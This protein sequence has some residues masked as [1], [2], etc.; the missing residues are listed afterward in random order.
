MNTFIESIHGRNPDEDRISIVT[1]T[2]RRRERED[3]SLDKSRWMYQ[4]CDKRTKMR[5]DWVKKKRIWNYMMNGMEGKIVNHSYLVPI[6]C[7][8][9][10]SLIRLFKYYY[11]LQL[12]FKTGKS[13]SKQPFIRFHCSSR[14]LSSLRGRWKRTNIAQICCICWTRLYTVRCSILSLSLIQYTYCK[15][16]DTTHKRER[17]WR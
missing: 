9:L 11:F 2:W 10:Y 15:R 12:P 13:T 7:G 3:R 8:S 14:H 16:Y 4:E 1:T 17:V 5:W 6:T